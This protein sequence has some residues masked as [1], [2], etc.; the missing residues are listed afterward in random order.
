MVNAEHFD[1]LCRNFQE[2]NGLEMKRF[3]DDISTVFIRSFVEANGLMSNV[4]NVMR[5]LI[6]NNVQSTWMEVLGMLRSS[7]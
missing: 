3:E 1:A 6:L 4:Q 2:K 7:F 5:T